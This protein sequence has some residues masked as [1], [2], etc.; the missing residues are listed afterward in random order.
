MVRPD[1]AL[2]CVAGQWGRHRQGGNCISSLP[3]SLSH[4]IYVDTT[5]F[6]CAACKCFD[7]VLNCCVLQGS[8]AD[9]VKGAMVYLQEQ[10]A[11]TGLSEHCHMLL[12]VRSSCCEHAYGWNSCAG[13][14]SGG[15]LVCLV[16]CS[17]QYLA[18]APAPVLQSVDKPYCK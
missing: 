7:L 10:L 18:P 4:T 13:S 1:A 12:Q 3:S 8:G 17:I 9:I 14:S 16:S 11:S 2:L 15:V 5:Y 6:K